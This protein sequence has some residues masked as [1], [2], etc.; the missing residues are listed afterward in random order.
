MPI[1]Y[2]PS[3]YAFYCEGDSMTEPEHQN[4]CDI[5]K[6]IRSAANGQQIRHSAYPIEEGYDDTTMDALTL[7]IEK[8]RMERELS[9]T[10]ENQE[11]TDAEEKYI[12]NA[13]KQK[14]K[15]RKKGPTSSDTTSTSPAQASPPDP[16]KSPASS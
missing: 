7:R 5:N 16:Q 6:M 3:P 8:E 1:L 4:S 13:V 15:I 14:F 10:F 2:E 11:F 12:P 9:V